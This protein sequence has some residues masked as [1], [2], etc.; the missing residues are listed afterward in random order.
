MI[1]MITIIDIYIYLYISTHTPNTGNEIT[2]SYT[3]SLHI[4]EIVAN[5]NL[6]LIEIGTSTNQPP[7]TDIWTSKIKKKK[8]MQIAYLPFVSYL[9][10]FCPIYL[11]IIIIFSISLVPYIKAGITDKQKK[12]IS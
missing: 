6:P 9:T 8:L 7:N 10:T 2:I 3:P 11:F 12:N 1:W 5:G 4:N